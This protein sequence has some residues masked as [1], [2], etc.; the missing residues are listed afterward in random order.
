M[1]TR[2]SGIC[3]S[4]IMIVGEAPGESEVRAGEP[5]IGASGEELNRMLHEAGI[6]R[7]EC[8]TTNVARD[9]PRQNDIGMF[10]A[11]R[12]KDITQ[13]HKP[14]RDKYVTPE[15][16]EGVALLQKEVKLCNPNVI[17]AF[18]N[19]A[20][21]VLTGE[22]GIKK[23]R[24]SELVSDWLHRADGTQIKVIP[25]YHPAY[26]LRDWSARGITIHDLKRAKRESLTSEIT[27][28]DY[29]YII[30]PSYSQVISVLD[31]LQKLIEANP[32]WLSVDIETRAGHTACIGV[33]WSK[34][35]AMCIPLM[36]VHDQSGYWKIEEEVEIS[37]R[38]YL[39]LSHTNAKIIGHNFSYDAQ[40][41]YRHLLFI[42][43]LAHDTMIGHH[44]CFS[45]TPKALDYVSSMYNEHYVYWKDDGKLWD[46]SMGE[47]QYWGYNCDDCC[48]TFE[49]AMAEIKL[50]DALGRNE[51]HSFQQALVWPVLEAMNHGINVDI[52]V[53]DAFRISLKAE[54]AERLSY[55]NAVLGHPLNLNSP[56]QV[57]ELFYRDLA[58]RPVLNRKT[59]TPSC[60]EEALRTIVKRE[61]LLA[62]LVRRIVEYRSLGVF[63][64]TFVEAKLDVD[65]RLRCSYNICGTETFRFNSG[66]NA[67]GSGC[68][69]QN[70]STGGATENEDLVLPNLRTMYIPDTGHTFFDVDLDS[71]DLRIVCWESDCR[72]MK[73][74]L[75]E[76]AKVYVEVAKEYYKDPSFT[77][78]HRM[79][80]IFKSLC[81]GTHYL[82]SASGLAGR[83]GLPVREI[84]KI[85]RWYFGKFPEIKRWQE[86][87][88]AKVRSEKVVTNPFGYKIHIF[89][90]I[91]DETFREAIAWLP[92]STVACLINRGFMNLYKNEKS[93]Q[94]LLQTHDSLSGQFPTEKKDWAIQTIIANCTIPLPYSDP[95]I[96][97][98][99]IK[100]SEKSWGDCE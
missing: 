53:R 51:V 91:T 32:C 13:Y 54:M 79:Y 43:N 75:A 33:A 30:R 67:F 25:M 52:Q 77:K 57:R 82:G 11:M 17:L 26:I 58:Q 80:T 10:V 41:F 8:F 27:R 97:P 4:K 31:T 76:G 87:F 5:F 18:G 45:N 49:V 12:K 89:D 81:H 69:F 46:A 61:P 7:S 62:P 70:I 93:I 66:E 73:A 16:L 15:I 92:Q 22:W 94:V 88:C 55:I 74:M 29:D 9:R 100:T 78:K 40:Y 90:R 34:E 3:P 38:L 64:N 19:V 28:R 2:P 83:L 85:Q 36:C 59:K 95:C 42:P 50:V 21:W 48:F 14:Y 39:L 96:I 37:W 6:M 71:A 56:K 20:L 98:V 44:T 86:D 47:D 68:N 72:E 99:G 60:D 24:G 63:L 1:Q 84:E 65:G 35:D 23:W